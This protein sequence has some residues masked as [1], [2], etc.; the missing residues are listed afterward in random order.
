MKEES[1]VHKMN[2]RSIPEKLR[3]AGFKVNTAKSQVEEIK[4]EAMSIVQKFH[5]TVFLLGFD[6]YGDIPIPIP[7]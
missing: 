2:E 5:N 3:A 1:T 7:I 6:R 4:Q